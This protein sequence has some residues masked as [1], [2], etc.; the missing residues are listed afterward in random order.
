MRLDWMQILLARRRPL[1]PFVSYRKTEKKR[2]KKLDAMI[3]ATFGSS[4]P[5]PSV[6]RGR[7]GG[8]VCQRSAKKKD[9]KQKRGIIVRQHPLASFRTPG[10]KKN[11]GGVDGRDVNELHR[12]GAVIGRQYLVDRLMGPSRS[13]DP[14]VL[15]TTGIPSGK[16]RR[17]R[18]EKATRTDVPGA[19]WVT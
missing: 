19:F 18:M 11:I 17:E 16:T 10:Q 8:V 4:G 9:R 13:C 1:F 3:D 7:D 14:S 2:K 15:S 5:A 6:D 12:T